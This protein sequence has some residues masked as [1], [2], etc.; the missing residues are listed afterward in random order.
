MAKILGV[1][2]EIMTELHREIRTSEYIEETRVLRFNSQ[3]EYAE[4]IW[5]K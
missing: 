4:V 1:V 2:D 5:M 3:V